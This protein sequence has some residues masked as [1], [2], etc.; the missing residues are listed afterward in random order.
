MNRSPD[1]GGKIQRG[2]V[3]EGWRREG[4]RESQKVEDESY[5]GCWVKLMTTSGFSGARVACACVC[6]CVWV[7]ERGEKRKPESRR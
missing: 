4:R 7:E 3:E 5:V 6:V 1:E 2:G